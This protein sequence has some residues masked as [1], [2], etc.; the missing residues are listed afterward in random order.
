MKSDS[1]KR[2]QSGSNKQ[3]V[4]H[5]DLSFDDDDSDE[6]VPFVGTHTQ[7]SLDEEEEVCVLQFLCKFII[8]T[9]LVANLKCYICCYVNLV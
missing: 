9:V 3:H 2:K 8:L 7:D 6:E 5:D 1:K 4:V